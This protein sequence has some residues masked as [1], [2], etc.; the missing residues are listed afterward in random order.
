MMPDIVSKAG[1][2]ANHLSK[3]DLFDELFLNVWH[4]QR[5]EKGKDLLMDTVSPSEQTVKWRCQ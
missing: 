5:G 1:V 3:A 4:S 2:V